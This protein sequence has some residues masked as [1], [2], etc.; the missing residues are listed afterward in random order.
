MKKSHFFLENREKLINI[1]PYMGN[2]KVQLHPK[3]DDNE[4]R[5]RQR[6]N[7]DRNRN[8]QGRQDLRFE[9]IQWIQGK[10]CRIGKQK[11]T[12]Q[13]K[14]DQGKRELPRVMESDNMR[15]KP[16]NENDDYGNKT[17]HNEKTGKCTYLKEQK[18]KIILSRE[19]AIRKV[20]NNIYLIRSQT[21]T[22]WYKV[23]WNGKEW[24]CN[25]PD[26]TKNGHISPCKH[27]LALKIK[28]ESGVYKIEEETSKIESK[29]YSQN[30][31]EYNLAQM[32]EF[33]IFDQFL[34]QLVS[35]IDDPEQHMGKP[36]MHLSDKIYCCIMKVYSQ[37][38]SR[39]AKHLYHDALERQQIVHAPHFNIVTK[40]LN[41]KWIAPILYELVHLSAQS[42]ASVETDFAIDSSGFRCS[43]F[44]NYCEEKHGTKRKRNWL[45]VHICTGV[46][47]NIV[48]DVVITDEHSADSPQLKK[49]LKNISNHFTINE[50][51]ADM[52]YSSKNNLR[53]ID[54][55]GGKPFI[56]FK[57]NATGKRGG[58]LW[59]KTFHYFQLHKDE[60]LE[61]YHKRSN[62]ESTFSAIKK[63]FGESVKSKNRIAQENELLCKIIAYNITV[64]IHEMVQLNGS[65][66]KLFFNGLSKELS[67]VK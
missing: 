26:F 10:S 48:A 52:A 38:S 40:T 64:L 67:I 45:K 31:S 50:I 17:F 2:N 13:L 32:Q 22:G 30:W 66:E 1:K 35:S 12:H 56:P 37:L 49:M 58:A 65:T 51:S 6:K 28:Y 11:V 20:N 21:G 36:Q 27:L 14:L 43:T 15:I 8:N 33:E 47:T 63:K 62:V 4:N 46:N 54:S 34:Y 44:G 55:F 23:Q 53:L 24:V 9:K 7:R 19:H 60:F 57:K 18:A 29:T 25:C 16:R 59:R 39:R 41:K 42:L 5:N 3:T 61:H